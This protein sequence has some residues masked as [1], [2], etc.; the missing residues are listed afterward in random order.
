[1]AIKSNENEDANGQQDEE[2]EEVK[3]GQNMK[4]RKMAGGGSKGE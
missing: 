1:M 3:A 4:E 2:E